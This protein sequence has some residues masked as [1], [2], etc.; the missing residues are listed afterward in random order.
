ADAPPEC[1]RRL[2]ARVAGQLKGLEVVIQARPW[3]D[4]AVIGAAEL[5]TRTVFSQIILEGNR[6]PGQG[7][8]QKTP[9]MVNSPPERARD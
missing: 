7:R 9:E 8:L 3:V 4:S 5:L 2:N 6:P 1:I